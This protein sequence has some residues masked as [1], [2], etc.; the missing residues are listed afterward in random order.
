[1]PP[2][3]SLPSRERDWNA[4]ELA[5]DGRM[6]AVS[7][8]ALGTSRKPKV[9]SCASSSGV[10]VGP[11]ALQEL[12]SKL[13]N[14]HWTAI[15]SREEYQMLVL[16]EPPV[17]ESEI[18]SSLRWS[19][20]SAIEYPVADAAL[21]WMRIPTAAYSNTAER[22]LY[23]VVARQSLVQ[24]RSNVFA[25]AGVH[26][27]A[28]DVRETALRN[29]AALASH[30]GEAVGLVSVSDAGVSTIFTFK[31]ELYL[32]RFIGQPID[33]IRTDEGRKR[34]FFERL[35]AQVGQSLELMA[36]SFPFFTVNRIFI[37][38]SEYDVDPGRFLADGLPAP[39]ETLDLA[40]LFDISA[41]SMLANRNNQGKYLIPLGAALRGMN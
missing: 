2:R 16:P 34:K 5:P 10:A 11:A 3:F 32:D 37:A 24:E 31:G 35:A 27:H 1:M 20:G 41:V 33:E 12:A 21:S 26:L 6:L 15:L 7:V 17:L 18:A 4:V 40:A 30:E 25:K 8:R 19:L 38:P 29:I 9:I 14:A 36:R 23:A 13:P 22:Q 39:V 28:V